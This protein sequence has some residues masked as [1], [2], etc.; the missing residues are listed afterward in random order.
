M[1]NDSKTIFITH[2]YYAVNNPD[3]NLRIY[4][5][6]KNSNK[7]TFIQCTTKEEY[8]QKIKQYIIGF[9][10]YS[11]NEEKSYVS[12]FDYLHNNENG[13]FQYFLG[14]KKSKE[15]MYTNQ[16]KREQ[17]AILKDGSFLLD[18]D[19]PKLQKRWS[20]YIENSN[21]QLSVLSFY[22]EYIDRNI[23]AKDLQKKIA[24]DVMPKFLKYCGYDNPKKSLEWVVALHTDNENNYHYHISWVEK[25]PC[26]KSKTGNLSYRRKLKITDDERNFLKRQ[27]ILTIERQKVYTPALKKLEKNLDDLKKYFNPNDCNFTLKNIHN[28]EIEEKIV[29]LGYLLNQIRGTDRK[30]IK[31]NSLPHNELGIEIRNITK[32]IKREIFRDPKIKQIQ[33][34]IKKSVRNINGILIDIDKR[35]NINVIEFKN[36][37]ENKMLNQK[38]ERNDSYILN[39]IVNH[40]LYNHSYRKKKLEKSD[41]KLEDII[42]EISYDSYTENYKNS[43]K[44]SLLKIRSNILKNVFKGNTTKYEIIKTLNR[45]V[46]EQD[47]IAQ[48]FYKMLEEKEYE[49]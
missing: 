8:R 6:A 2:P 30:Y 43:K 31:Y 33:N 20:N 44:N 45:L 38:L 10:D 16:M 19:V 46:Y 7:W 35:N 28:V 49:K 27:A 17:M 25:N 26:Y 22:R 48:E 41:F 5:K 29:K 18:K 47:K 13:M 23:N 14:S 3:N 42:Q 39:A 24:V 32:E 36:E 37:L 4:H 9:F 11:R 40:A 21:I 12:I 34:K 15:T 1:F